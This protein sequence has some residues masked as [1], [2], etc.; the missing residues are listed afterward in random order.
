VGQHTINL[1]FCS[2]SGFLGPPNESSFDLVD[3]FDGFGRDYKRSEVL[4]GL[5]CNYRSNK[6]RTAE[7]GDEVPFPRRK[8]P[9][10]LIFKMLEIHTFYLPH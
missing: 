1:A 8:L 10:T 3:E 4:C 2:G 7:R 9:R 6:R 5:R